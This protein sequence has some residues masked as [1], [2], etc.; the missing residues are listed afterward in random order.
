[1]TKADDIQRLV[2]RIDGPWWRLKPGMIGL[3]RFI[4]D[5]HVRGAIEAGY[6]WTR[7]YEPVCS[8]CPRLAALRARITERTDDE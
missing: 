3:K 2:E 4:P 1:M 8:D 7:H 5:K 6:G